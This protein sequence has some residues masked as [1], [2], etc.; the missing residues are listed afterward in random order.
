VYR[1]SNRCEVP[2]QQHSSS[3]LFGVEWLG[4]VGWRRR[5]WVQRSI[6][7]RE[8]LVKRVFHGPPATAAGLQPVTTARRG[9]CVAV[10]G[11]GTSGRLPCGSALGCEACGRRTDLTL[12]VDAITLLG[13][14]L[15]HLLQLH[16]RVIP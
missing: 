12:Y 10:I 13:H 16:A 9:R 1:I 11:C 3:S 14:L 4:D 6:G 15:N 7:H 2:L 5:Q 8:F